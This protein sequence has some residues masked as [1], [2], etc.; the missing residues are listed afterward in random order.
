MRWQ[1]I[2]EEV[3]A[4]KRVISLRYWT[5]KPYRSPQKEI[6]RLTSVSTQE[7]TMF[8]L[9]TGMEAFVDGKPVEIAYLAA[10][11]GLS[12]RAFE[13]WFRPYFKETNEF[14]GCIVFFDNKKLYK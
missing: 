4:G 5:G 2:A 10:N 6:K 1:Q 8:N 3:N 11:D 12:F 9:T 7:V 13:A 14:H